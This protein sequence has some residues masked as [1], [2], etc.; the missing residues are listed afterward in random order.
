MRI[1]KT[2]I[3]NANIILPE[4]VITG[5]ILIDGS[6]I[7]EIGEIGLARFNSDPD[8]TP[9]NAGGC[10]VMPGMIDMHCDAIE[11][12]IQPR[13]NT[14][15]PINMAFYELE[16]KL[17]A[18][19]ITTMYHSLCLSD[20]WGVR[21]KDMVIAII[22]S[23]NELKQFR[24]MI[25]HKIHLRYELTYLDGVSI[26]EGLIN[27]KSIDFMSYMD[28]TPGQGQ[29]K[30]AQSLKHFTIQSYGR[31]EREIEAFLEK[32]QDYRAMINWSKLIAL[33]KLAKTKGIGLATHDDDT[34][35][36]IDTLLACKGRV[37]EFP[38]NLDTALYA[39]SQGL[40]VCVGAPNIVRGRSHSNNMRAIDAITGNAADIVCSD[41]LPG[42]MLPALFHLIREGIKL[43]EAVKLVTANPAGALGINQ[44]VGTVEVGKQA[45]LIIVELHQDYPV[46]RQT[47]V[48]GTTVFQ[49]DFQL[50]NT[51]RVDHIC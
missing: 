34:R 7:S 46:V 11:K 49:S 37:S 51:E 19:G 20:E 21:D 5:Y 32:S 15:F 42:A 33:A 18:S 36:K 4:Q 29:F 2:C 9:V 13:P 23:I 28:H 14:Q 12:E 47:L 10:Y 25:N 35:E 44:E 17:A 26:L 40:H 22:N 1:K 30:D 48:G 6:K 45:D 16:K 50:L 39:K 41:Y 43:P 38:I 31:E 8:V 24:A 3:Y 27:E